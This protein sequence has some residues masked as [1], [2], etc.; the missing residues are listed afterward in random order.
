MAAVT[1]TVT[2][3]AMAPVSATSRSHSNNRV[4]GCTVHRATATTT[5]AALQP[6]QGHQQQPQR[7]LE[8][9]TQHRSLQQ[10]DNSRSDGHSNCATSRSQSINYRIYRSNVHRVAVTA[11]AAH[12]GGQGNRHSSTASAI[13]TAIAT[14]TATSRSQSI[15]NGFYC[16]VQTK[17]ERKVYMSG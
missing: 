5:A 3:T 1:N 12:S 8:Q 9:Q 11:T 6:K 15:N 16:R 17:S 13:N 2:A 7:W 4:Y 14:V 10:T